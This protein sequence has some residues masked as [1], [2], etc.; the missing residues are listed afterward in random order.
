VMQAS[1]LNF[2]KELEQRLREALLKLPA[3]GLS[4]ICLRSISWLDDHD[5]KEPDVE[6]KYGFQVEDEELLAIVET[7]VDRVYDFVDKTEVYVT[8]DGIYVQL[9]KTATNPYGRDVG[10]DKW[11]IRLE[12]LIAQYLRI[13][14][15]ENEQ[16]LRAAVEQTIK[17]V[18]ELAS[19]M[20]EVTE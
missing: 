12:E 15:K 19:R 2:E 6:I 10:T 9:F 8:T 14:R 3:P 5:G 13:V 16:A 17:A 1:T 18:E 11:Y 7:I 20:E 4:K